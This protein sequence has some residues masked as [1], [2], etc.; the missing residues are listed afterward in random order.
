MRHVAALLATM[1]L[2]LALVPSTVSAAPPQRD[3]WIVQLSDGVNPA[4][5]APGLAKEH[6]GSVGYVY[7]HALN[8]F[9]F[10]GSAAAA[11]ALTHN[12][13][14]TLVE[15]DAEVTLEDTQT[16]ATWGLDR[17]DQ[18]A[19]P[20]NGSYLYEHTGGRHGVHHRYRDPP[21]HQE[22]GGRAS[23]GA[24]FVG[25]G[26][27][28]ID[29]NGHGTHVAGTIGGS[30]Y[31]VAKGVHLVAVRVFGCSGGARG[32]RSSRASTG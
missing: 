18:R 10:R 17:I 6:G 1:A 29:C 8:G 31:G 7:R 28:G 20:L 22:F 16:G 13:K 12:P 5:A 24:D 9:S 25:D 2:I 3:T 21:T 4:A 23:V 15:A 19:L 30:T 26:Q 11:A 14:V 32:R 27:D